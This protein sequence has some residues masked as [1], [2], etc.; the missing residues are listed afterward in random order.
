MTVTARANTEVLS[1]VQ[2][3]LQS[4]ID[5]F[6]VPPGYLLDLGNEFDDLRDNLANFFVTII[7]ATLLV[8]I[9]MAALFESLLLPMSILMSVPL[10][11]VGV[12]W[13]MFFMNTALDTIGIIGCVLMVGVVVRNGIVIIDH[14]NILR[15]HSGLSRHDAIVQAGKDRFRPVVMTALTTILGVL[16]LA[17]EASAG[18]TV[19]FVSLGRAFISGLTTGTILTLVI[20]PLFYTLFEDVRNITGYF[21][22]F[23]RVIGRDDLGAD[24]TPVPAPENG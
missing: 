5:K 10:A 22:I 8:Y 18:T 24:E 11:F 4:I 15:K 2:Q 14:I 19:S 20:V 17:F 6:P 9:V 16:P 23:L 3:E 13:D 12:Y 1:E 7:F 21:F